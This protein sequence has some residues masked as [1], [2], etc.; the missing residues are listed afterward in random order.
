M[1]WAVAS[2]H[3]LL[4]QDRDAVRSRLGRVAMGKG[5]TGGARAERERA[6]REEK[7]GRGDDDHVLG[8]RRIGTRVRGATAAT[9]TTAGLTRIFQSGQ[10]AARTERLRPGVA[11]HHRLHHDA[12]M[13]SISAA[14]NGQT[15]VRLCAGNQRLQR[16]QG[17]QQQQN[18]CEPS[19][20]G[21]S[22]PLRPSRWLVL[23]C[24]VV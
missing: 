2:S 15:G 7:S 4:V 19:P 12:V 22:I 16:Q 6:R 17:R 8:N 10:E 23:H 1:P 11:Q 5:V 20:H 9:A 24:I 21:Q 18:G 3:I 13:S 14:A